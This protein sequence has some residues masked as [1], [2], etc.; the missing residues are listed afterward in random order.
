MKKRNN[1]PLYDFFTKWKKVEI[2]SG[3]RS[4]ILFYDY[5][6]LYLYLSPSG[7]GG[8]FFRCSIGWDV[9]RGKRY[10]LPRQINC[11]RKRAYFLCQQTRKDSLVDI[12]SFSSISTGFKSSIKIF[13]FS[14]EATQSSR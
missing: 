14:A 9:E 3:K 12:Y 4:Q 13:F 11:G 5:A 2:F 6:F 1:F 7:G 8:T 10:K